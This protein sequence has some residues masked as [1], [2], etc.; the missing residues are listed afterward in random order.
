MNLYPFVGMDDS[1]DMHIYMSPFRLH[2][3]SPM[4][5]RGKPF[6]DGVDRAI[7]PEQTRELLQKLCDYF[8]DYDSRKKKK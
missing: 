7:E 4:H 2:K 1:G 6:P 5:S 3:L 8:N